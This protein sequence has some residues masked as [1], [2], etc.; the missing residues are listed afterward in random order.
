MRTS[1]NVVA[2]IIASLTLYVTPRV[3]PGTTSLNSRY[4]VT[5]KIL[6]ALGHPRSP[7]Y[8]ALTVLLRLPQS[9]FEPGT[10][11]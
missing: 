6:S 8:S 11:P 3:I 7:R 10:C 1:P 4:N 5:Y 2:K 9:G